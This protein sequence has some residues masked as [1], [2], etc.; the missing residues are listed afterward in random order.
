M[1]VFASVLTLLIAAV[2]PLVLKLLQIGDAPRIR[3]DM[4]LSLSLS[5][6]VCKYRIPLKK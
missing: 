2:N 1:F 6:C 5:L 4:Y 3:K